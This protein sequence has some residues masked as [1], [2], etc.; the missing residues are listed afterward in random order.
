[1]WLSRLIPDVLY[2]TVKLIKRD[3]Q[4]MRQGVEHKNLVC[5]IIVQNLLSKFTDEFSQLFHPIEC[6]WDLVIR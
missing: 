1:M 2:Q 3:K 5:L 6:G 4:F